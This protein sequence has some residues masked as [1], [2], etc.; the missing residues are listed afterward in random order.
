MYCLS[1]KIEDSENDGTIDQEENRK[2][3]NRKVKDSRRNKLEWK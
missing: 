1:E 3:K 2:Y